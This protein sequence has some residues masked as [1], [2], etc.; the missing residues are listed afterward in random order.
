M[1]NRGSQT[2]TW[3]VENRPLTVT[4]GASFV[5]DGDGNRVKKTEGGQTTL[6]INQYYEKNLTTGVV[7]TSY[8]LGGQPVATREGTTLRYIHQ[9]SLGSTSVMTT[10]AGVLDSAAAYDPFGATRNGSVSI[11]KGFTGQRLDGTGLYFYNARYFDPLIGRFINADSVI[12]SVANPQYLNRY[13][14]CLNNPL[15]YTD[16][17]GRIVEFENET[18]CMRY[19]T[20]ALDNGSEIPEDIWEKCMKRGKLRCAWYELSTVAPKLTSTLE[21]AS[22]TITVSASSNLPN[23]HK[24]E[25]GPHWVNGVLTSFSMVLDTGLPGGIERVAGMM[26]H[27][28]FHV[29][30]DLAGVYSQPNVNADTIFEETLACIYFT[31][32]MISLN[33]NANDYFQQTG[34]GT[35]QW[36]GQYSKRSSVTQLEVASYCQ[37]IQAAYGLK[38]VN[39]PQ[40]PNQGIIDTLVFLYY[41]YYPGR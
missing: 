20:D 23:Q 24:G 8:Y 32:T 10:S 25:T 13:S 6:Y 34:D 5:Y 12:Q 4:G 40:Y 14:Y 9:D 7:T 21:N 22:Q 31:A 11:S 37:G 27:E 30:A 35:M 18:E 17:S 36:L 38:G 2:I 28:S 3:D 15:T 19:L 1:T 16:P 39:L 29:L 33:V 41:N 26:A